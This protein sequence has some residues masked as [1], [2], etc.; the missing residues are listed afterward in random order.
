[1]PKLPS[2][3]RYSIS[4]R[5]SVVINTVK[6]SYIAC[7]CCLPPPVAELVLPPG[8]RK[9]VKDKGDRGTKCRRVCFAV[10]HERSS[11]KKNMDGDTFSGTPPT[12]LPFALSISSLL[13]RPSVPD[14]NVELQPPDSLF[15]LPKPK[16]EPLELGELQIPVPLLT[17]K[18]EPPDG[19]ENFN[20]DHLQIVSV[21]PAEGDHLDS[22]YAESIDRD[23]DTTVLHS[24]LRSAV[25][26]AQDPP[27]DEGVVPF[28]AEVC[29][30][31]LIC[32]DAIRKSRILYESLRLFL[33]RQERARNSE[34]EYFG[35]RSRPDLK[36]GSVMCS[37]GLSLN[38]ERRFVGSVPGIEIGDLFFFRMEM[39]VIGLHC[40]LQAGIDY[41]PASRSLTGEPIATSVVASGG[42]EDD[43]DGGDVL[44]YTGHGGRIHFSTKHIVHQKLERGNLALERS[45]RYGI[46]VRVIRGFKC[47]GSPSGKQLRRSLLYSFT[48][49]SLG[50]VAFSSSL[51]PSEFC[52][53]YKAHQSS[54]P[55]GLG[56]VYIYDGL[57]RICDT[58]LDIG[59]SGFSVYKYRLVRSPQ[60]P[61]MGSSLFKLA[62]NMKLNPNCRSGL[63]NFDLSN[64]KEKIPVYLFNDLDSD[65]GPMSYSYTAS[66]I[67]PTYGL[68]MG[69]SGGCDCVSGCSLGCFCMRRNG[70]DFPYDREGVLVRGRPLIYECGSLCR[71]PPTCRNRV[72]QTGVKHQ[73]EVFRTRESGWGVR[74]LDL[75]KAGKF[76]CEFAGVVLTRQ[77]AVLVSMNGDNLIYAA[78]FPH[79]WM[80]WGNVSNIVPHSG[81][82]DAPCLSPLEYGIDVSRIRSVGC[83]LNHSFVPNVLVQFVLYDHENISY[84]H[85][86]LFAMEN[87]PPMR[88]LTIDY[89]L[90]NGWIRNFIT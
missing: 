23:S 30:E 15:P 14:L 27:C 29:N 10:R 43:E 60:Q 44:I 49:K 7:Y 76:I 81:Q 69:N 80:E 55:P 35:P 39:V 54:G 63:V 75:I 26:P 62:G 50:S 64:G 42:Y 31:L 83:Y 67:Y 85:L 89:G 11:R 77:Q 90:A 38:R 86:M 57:Y 21:A 65:R 66:P 48:K 28:S 25:V 82:L 53:V 17:P 56:K 12:V 68:W 24:D 19:H 8:G 45:M 3:K 71:C 13:F 84:P 37:V 88:E 87:I 79:R 5:G 47:G 58:W 18:E 61:E 2:L 73:L 1:M 51:L 52:F 72:T 46:E 16:E 70:G 40:Q 9:R 59:K 20:A 78:Q 41:I 34:D 32:R 74:S 6:D 4:F 33:V 22:A 36:A